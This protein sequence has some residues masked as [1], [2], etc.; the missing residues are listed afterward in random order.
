MNTVVPEA[1]S[2][3]VMTALL[4][5]GYAKHSNGEAGTVSDEAVTRLTLQPVDPGAP[6]PATSG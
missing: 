4:V 1:S 5:P 2:L 6:E 3:P